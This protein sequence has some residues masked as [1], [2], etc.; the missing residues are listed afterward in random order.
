MFDPPIWR[1]DAVTRRDASDFVC[2]A[3]IVSQ[4]LSETPRTFVTD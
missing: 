4:E 2:R 1:I 3:Q